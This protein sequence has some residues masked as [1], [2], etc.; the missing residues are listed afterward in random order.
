MIMKIGDSMNKGKG[1]LL[2]FL[3]VLFT[4]AAIAGGVSYALNNINA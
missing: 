1:K 4:L 2:F 3:F